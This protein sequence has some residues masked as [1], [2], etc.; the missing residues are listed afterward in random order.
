M[1]IPMHAEWIEHRRAGDGEVLGWIL[2]EGDRFTAIDRLGRPRLSTPDWVEAEECLEDLGLGYL[3]EPLE[4]VL[5]DGN[6]LAVRL[7]E[8][9]TSGIR[10]K[11]EDW[12]DITVPLTTHSLPFP[13]PQSL[14]PSTGTR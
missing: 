14:R 13:A 12:G 3:A 10:V 2:P 9:S 6:V 1:L 5:E 4:L 11:E 8:V 7:T